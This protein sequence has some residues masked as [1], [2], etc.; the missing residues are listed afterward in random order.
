MKRGEEEAARIRARAPSGSEKLSAAAVKMVG[1]I[2]TS[3]VGVRVDTPRARLDETREG[4]KVGDAVE[5]VGESVG[6]RV[7][8]VDVVHAEGKTRASCCESVQKNGAERG[9]VASR[10]ESWAGSGEGRHG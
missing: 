6:G 4:E 3:A 9:N 10:R 7:V 1:P 8:R 5:A 2:R